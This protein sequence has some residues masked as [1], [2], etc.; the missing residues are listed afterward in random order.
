MTKTDIAKLFSNGEFE[1][2][3]E[4]IAENAEWTV[5]EEDQFFGKKAIIEQCTQVSNY[6][7][8]VTT[9]FTTLTC[10][11]DENHVV[12]DGTAEFLRDKK[13]ISFVSTCDIYKFNAKSEILK[14]TS[15]CIPSK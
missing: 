12:I 13:R 7:K 11:S 2:T 15:Y 6:F 10:V 9:K 5:I 8:S 4:F 1:K 14:I 3:F